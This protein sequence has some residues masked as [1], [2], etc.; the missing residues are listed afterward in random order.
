ADVAAELRRYVEALD[1]DPDRLEAIET[2]LAVLDAIKRKHGGTV[3]A[4]IAE[5]ERL[6]RQVGAT[7]D[8]VGAV[9]AA[10]QKSQ[11]A[12]ADLKAA[13]AGLTRAR[14]EGARGLQ[15]AVGEELLGRRW[16]GARLG[17]GLRQPRGSRPVGAETA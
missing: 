8:L 15:K 1:S 6:E 2:R 9:A 16:E 17:S 11:Q 4:A 5:K 13:A 3:E 14:A 10:E 12:R 7:E